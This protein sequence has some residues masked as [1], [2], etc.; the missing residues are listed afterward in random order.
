MSLEALLGRMPLD[1]PKVQASCCS[2]ELLR[3][4]N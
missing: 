1:D 2:Q 3:A 4:S